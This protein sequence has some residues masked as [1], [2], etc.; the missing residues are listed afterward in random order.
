MNEIAGIPYPEMR[1]SC[2]REQY[3]YVVIYIRLRDKDS[4]RPGV[5]DEVLKVRLPMKS[6]YFL[7][8]YHNNKRISVAA[9]PR[10]RS[11]YRRSEA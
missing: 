1:C 2:P 7:E 6:S 10:Q 9:R 5:V 11:N 8:Q 4:Y 3:K